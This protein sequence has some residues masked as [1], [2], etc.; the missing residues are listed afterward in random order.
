[1][2]SRRSRRL[3]TLDD[4][5]V[6]PAVFIVSEGLVAPPRAGFQIHLLSLARAL[7]HHVDVRAFAWMPDRESDQ[8]HRWVKSLP[9]GPDPQEYLVPIGEGE[10]EG[11]ALSRK[12]ACWRAVQEEIERR[13][14]P[15]DVLW[16]RE[17][18]TAMFAI[19]ALSRSLP[20]RRDMLHVYDVASIVELEME[21]ATD[22][23]F[24]S[25][26]PAVEAW[27]RRRFDLVRTLGEGMRSF[28]VERGLDAERVIVA[29]VGADPPSVRHVPRGRVERILYVGSH[30]RWQGLPVLLEAMR[31]L[32][33]E[34]ADVRL[35][36]VGAKREALAALEVPENVDVVGWVERAA[37]PQ[38]YVDHDL[39]VIPRPKSPLTD[40]V[41]PMK[42][43][44]AQSYHIPILATDLGALRE[45]TGGESAY[46]VAPDSA[47]ALAD[48]IRTLGAEPER[49]HEL[50]R[51]A[52]R[53]SEN[54][55]WPAIGARLAERLFG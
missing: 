52:L 24:A 15:G 44:E 45:V 20:R 46:L 31:T 12:V 43:V 29:P 9:A 35:S 16:V 47:A 1:M 36:V 40:T 14:R 50:H 38:L 42:S 7:A 27:L 8:W 55:A 21:L 32:S 2:R 41:I 6:R 33:S 39:F 48:G 10:R 25:L 49:L 18:P 5:S 26:K 23:R 51:A 28:L 30:E 53:R 11:N 34:G 3:P 37:I 22:V 19:P 54:F 17:L 4:C 13:A